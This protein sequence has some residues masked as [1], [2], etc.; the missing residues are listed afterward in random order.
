MGQPE[1]A[2]AHWLPA[3]PRVTRSRADVVGAARPGARGSRFTASRYALGAEGGGAARPSAYMCPPRNCARC[4]LGGVGMSKK[5]CRTNL[6]RSA[7]R[8]DIFRSGWATNDLTNA[9]YASLTPSDSLAEQTHFTT[10]YLASAPLQS[11]RRAGTLHLLRWPS[12]P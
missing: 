6:T 2:A 5:S 7:Q 10:T 1:S 11:P 8:I 9:P 4:L 3:S 12:R